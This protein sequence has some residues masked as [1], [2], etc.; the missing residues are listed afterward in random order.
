MNE[1]DA[2]AAPN[3]TRRA[4]LI[5]AGAAGVGAWAAPTII[6]VSA[7]AAATIAPCV[8]DVVAT[9]PVGA[10]PTGVAISSGFAYVANRML[11]HGDPRATNLITAV[12]TCLG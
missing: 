11:G 10:A 12:R 4:L 7:A 3:A 2:G 8:P 5:G 6:T 1:N 9:V